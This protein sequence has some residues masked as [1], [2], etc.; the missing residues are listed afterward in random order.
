MFMV[1]TGVMS[2]T[3]AV[4][5]DRWLWAA[6]FFKTRRLAVDATNTRKIRGGVV[7]GRLSFVAWLG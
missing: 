3:D 2:E 5:L 6:R 4:R 7:L 1:A